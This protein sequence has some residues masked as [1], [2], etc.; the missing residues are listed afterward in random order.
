MFEPDVLSA[1]TVTTMVAI[2]ALI[3][4]A[5]KGM[6][7]PTCGSALH[8]GHYPRKPRGH[9]P[10]EAAMTQRWSWSCSR[11]GCRGRVT[12]P[13][14]WFWGRLVY[15]AGAVLA[16]VSTEA[17]SP[18]ETRLRL[19]F[20]ASRQSV[21][22][23]RERFG[24]V[25]ATPTGRTIAGSIPL[26]EQERK[27]PRRMLSLWG[28]RW[29]YVVAMWQLLI[30]PLTGG[31]RWEANGQRIGP[32]APQRMNFDHHLRTLQDPDRTR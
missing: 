22:R 23:W 19:A 13:S 7:C 9:E 32:L 24:A 29:P 4:F 15:I 21:R 20:G 17:R 5:I 14:V 31:T 10:L 1:S 2:D 30:H 27:Q 11:D 26:D 8:A 6:G 25:W 28:D 12:P 16:L 3:A 18:E